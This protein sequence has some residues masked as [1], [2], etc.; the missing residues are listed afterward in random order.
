MKQNRDG[1]FLWL[2]SLSDLMILLFVFFVV[3]FSFT[4]RKLG[5][6]YMKHI[7]TVMGNEVIEADPIDEI[8]KK[9]LKWVVDR[10]LMDDI[11]V[12]QKE[13]S[14]ILQIKERLLFSSGDFQV[15]TDGL[16]TIKLIGSFLEQVPPPYRIGIEGH[17]DDNPI[18]SRVAE[19]NW[20]LSVKRAHS[21]LKAL[22]LTAEQKKRAVLLGYA[23][24]RPLLPNRDPAGNA[25]TENQ[26]KNRRVTIRIF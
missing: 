25:M 18:H 17:T 13:D 7:S 21:V 5:A 12:Q 14:L 24:M 8:Q 3:L 2:I 22:Q 4:F 9:L 23:E 26:Q 1:E 20:E 19:D 11:S 10:K 16:E 6:A 15:R